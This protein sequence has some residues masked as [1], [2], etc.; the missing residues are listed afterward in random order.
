MK[1]LKNNK[2]GT[3]MIMVAL[4]IFTVGCSEDVK[5]VDPSDLKSAKEEVAMN[6]EEELEVKGVSEVREEDENKKDENSYISKEEAE[7]RINAMFKSDDWEVVGTEVTG[8]NREMYIL[9]RKDVSSDYR[10]LV[11]KKTGEKFCEVST[12]VGVYC[13]VNNLDDVDVYLESV[14]NHPGKP[15]VK[16]EDSTYSY[17]DEDAL[18]NNSSNTDSSTTA[19]ND[20]TDGEEEANNSKESITSEEAKNMVINIY[21]NAEVQ[22]LIKTNYHGEEVW[23]VQFK[24]ESE[25]EIYDFVVHINCYTGEM[26]TE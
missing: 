22:E 10:F 7:A 26:Y 15:Y 8:D 24:T 9:Q 11:D 5:A 6:N 21:G 18:N 3:L 13:P 25:G 23:K 19:S 1:L 2:I 12:N 4:G 20:S 16:K 14:S 17:I